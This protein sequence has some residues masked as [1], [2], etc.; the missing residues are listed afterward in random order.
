MK[1]Y[2]LSIILIAVGIGIFFYIRKNS[3]RGLNPI[4]GVIMIGSGLLVLIGIIIAISK[5]NQ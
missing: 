4:A 5:A 2:T 1:K 3:G